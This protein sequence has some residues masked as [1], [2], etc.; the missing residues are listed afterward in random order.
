MVFVFCI[1]RFGEVADKRRLLI[2]EP[3]FRR[4][5]DDGL[6]PVLERYDASFSSALKVF[7]KTLKKRE[8]SIR[9]C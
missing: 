2:L 7:V 3:S 4:R 5:K 8:K 9:T 1:W 6:L